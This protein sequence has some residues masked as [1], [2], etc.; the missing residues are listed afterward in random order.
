MC[1]FA[2]EMMV[3]Y[4]YS[5]RNSNVVNVMSDEIYMTYSDAFESRIDSTSNSDFPFHAGIVS[6]DGVSCK[7]I[8]ISLA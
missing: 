5:F 3:V 4:V 1:S 6:I 7:V 8:A 2:I